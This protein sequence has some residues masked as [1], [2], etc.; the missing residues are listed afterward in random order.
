MAL[1]K[2]RDRM[3]SNSSILLDNEK[4]NLIYDGY[5]CVSYSILI[6]SKIQGLD[7][8]IVGRESHLKFRI[9]S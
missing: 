3:R 1:H 5:I 9:T 4:G 2:P 6:S 7:G 8:A